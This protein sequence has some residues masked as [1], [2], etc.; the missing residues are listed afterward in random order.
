M[1]SALTIFF[2]AHL[3]PKL[4]LLLANFASKGFAKDVSLVGMAFAGI[5]TL[6]VLLNPY[7]LL[8]CSAVDR[9]VLPIQHVLPI[10]TLQTA[11]MAA[12]AMVLAS[13]NAIANA[14]GLDR[15]V[16][17]PFRLLLVIHRRDINFVA[18]LYALSLIKH[19]AV[20]SAMAG[21]TTLIK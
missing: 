21:V 11:Q 12:V 10:S 8:D 7:V 16:A 13:K 20:R 2:S 14:T 18:L 9:I 3:Q 5:L 17:N 15:I 1:V 19:S 6:S 4:V